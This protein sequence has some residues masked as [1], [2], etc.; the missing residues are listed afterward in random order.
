MTQLIAQTKKIFAAEGPLAKKIPNYSPRAVQ[1]DMAVAVASALEQ[2]EI[3]LAEAGTGT[4]K[5]YAY[6]IPSILSGKKVIIS[7]GTKNLQDQLFYR[8]LPILRK[9]LSIPLKVALLKGRN[10]YL[11]HHRLLSH[12][13]THQRL[14]L[15]ENLSVIKEWAEQTKDGELDLFPGKILPA[16][17]PV[18]TST[19]DNCLGQDCSFYNKC[20]LYKARRQ[21]QE[22]DITIINHHLFFA[23]NNLKDSGFSEL[24]PESAA[25]IFDEAHQLPDIA[26]Q[27]LG[28]TLSSRQI[29]F[30]ARD[31]ISEVNNEA[32]EVGEV[33][34]LAEKLIAATSFWLASFGPPMRGPWNKVAHRPELKVAISNFK[35]VATD[36]LKLLELLAVRSK[37]LENC[38]KRVED[39]VQRF[40]RLT[41]EFNE[42]HIHWFE[43]NEEMF[44]LH[45]SPIYVGEFFQ[46]LL[47]KKQAWIFTS[48]TLSIGGDFSHFEFSLGLKNPLRLQLMS[49]FDFTTQALMYL[50]RHQ[51]DPNNSN[52]INEIVQQALPI[53]RLTKGRTFF[54]FTSH[55]A[56][57]QAA[58]Y[59][60][61]VLTNPLLIQGDAPKTQL[62]QRFCSRNDAILLGTTSFW[63]G[64]DVK[65]NHLQCVIIDKIPFMVPDDPILKARIEFYKRQGKNPFLE[66]QLPHA[67]IGMRQ[68]VGRLIRA[69][70][71]R[72]LLMI[73]DPRLLLKEYGQTV[74]SS[75]P[76]MP[77]THSLVDVANF[78]KENNE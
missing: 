38:Y 3:L 67:V 43:S 73:C 71:D 9:A 52:Y 11:C 51:T 18:I 46:T 57:K 63:E 34:V 1:V 24:L 49:P 41:G 54:L 62:L 68:G 53:L 65:D 35:V 55:R 60:S 40:D 8:D 14:D 30:L 31:L 58:Q 28:E 50:P 78:L 23:D 20:F 6:I 5:T 17:L 12:L 25:V 74:L 75:L 47:A 10:N 64:V 59:L 44:A 21:A 72:G 61:T 16:N 27:F 7:T 22:S 29:Y 45:H 76:P 66:Y 77:I 13:H 56:L 26:T 32:K 37:G 2:D 69:A 70:S 4:G 19:V 36:I 48:A 39:L 33:K 42:G 15:L